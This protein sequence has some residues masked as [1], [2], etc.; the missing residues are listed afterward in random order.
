MA[1]PVTPNLS[2][3]LNVAGHVPLQNAVREG[4]TTLDT[5]VA[6]LQARLLALETAANDS[7]SL[8]FNGD[9]G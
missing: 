1:A 2:L 9:P 3:P 7:N 5:V 8:H 4:F 6:D